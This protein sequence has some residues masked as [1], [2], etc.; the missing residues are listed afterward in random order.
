[1][2][3]VRRT[4]TLV[5]ALIILGAGI[6]PTLALILSQV[7][8]SF[9]IPFALIP[10]IRLTGSRDVM[11]IHADSMPVKFAAWTSAVLIVGLNVVLIALT[12]GALA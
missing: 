10:L 3:M 5:P 4:V 9:G 6:E 12:F 1:P 8:L 11:G 2:L 7:L